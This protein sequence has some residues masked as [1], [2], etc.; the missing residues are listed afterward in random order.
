MPIVRIAACAALLCISS[1][2]AGRKWPLSDAQLQ[3][4]VPGAHVAQRLDAD[5]NADG[6]IDTVLSLSYEDAPDRDAY[7]SVQVFWGH[8]Q[9]PRVTSDED[10]GDGGNGYANFESSPHGAPNLG[11]KKGILLVE[12]LTGGTTATQT[13]YRYRYDPEADDMRLIG[14]DAERYSR[15]NSHGSIKLSWNVVTGTRIVQRG[16]INRDTKRD[17][18][19]LAYGPERRSVDKSRTYYYMPDTPNPDELLDALTE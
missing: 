3:K 19:A 9:D 1:A 14:L 6:L 16:E 5:L 18:A 15:T 13:S 8:H 7:R 4:R 2:H 12:D 10:D 11:F 17:D